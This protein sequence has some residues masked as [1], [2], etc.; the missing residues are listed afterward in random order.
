[1]YH[2]TNLNDSGPGSL[3]EGVV[4]ANGPR[5]IVFEVSGTI[6]LKSKL[7]VETPCLTIAG[8]TAPGDGVTL[9]DQYFQ[10]RN[11]SDVV[12]RYLRVRLGDKNKPVGAD[13][14]LN[15]E[16]VHDVML[17]HVSASWGID[18]I[19]DLAYAS[20]VTL[21]W[22]I[23]A[24]ALNQS[25]HHKGEHAMLSSWR[26][27]KGNVTLH[28]NLFASS[29]NRHPTLGTSRETD[30]NSVVDFR[31]NV[32]YNWEGPTNLGNCRIDVIGN[33]Y[34]PGPNTT[35]TRLPLSVKADRLDVHLAHG[36]LR[37]NLFEHNAV[38]TR[39][40]YLA[41]NYTSDDGSS[42]G[43]TTRAV[44][45]AGGPYVSAAEAPA[46]Q[47][48]RPR[49]RPCSPARGRRARVTRSTVAWCRECARESTGAST[50]KTRSA[51]GPSWSG[52]SAPPTATATVWPTIGNAPTASTRHR[53]TIATPTATA[54][55]IPTSRNTSTGCAPGHGLDPSR[56]EKTFLE[57]PVRVVI[58]RVFP[59]STSS[60]KS[61]PRI[62]LG[63]Q[64]MNR[65][66][67]S[68]GFTLIELL[69]VIAIIA[70]LIALL[71]PAVQAAREAAR[72]MSCVNNLKQIGIAMHN[73]HDVTGQLPS[74]HLTTGPTVGGSG[75]DDWS[76]FTMML[77]YMELGTLYNALNFTDLLEPAKYGNKYNSTV[78]FSKINTFLCPS[79]PVRGTNPDGH[80]NYAG[81]AG[82][83]PACTN[84]LL[85]LIGPD[86]RQCAQVHEQDREFRRHHRR[87]EQHRGVQRAG[88]GPH[89]G[90]R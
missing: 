14:T 39:D 34:R 53:P 2:V 11:T 86:R 42:Y 84:T 85:A 78:T 23:F 22:S 67:R 21:Q 52:P 36:Y 49:T 62:L 66:P 82:S 24:E 45:E 57:L 87:P 48:P 64:A 12:V 69:V 43:S 72:R 61:P 74:G 1:M 75:W 15:V 83:C 37:D 29:R 44:F 89:A 46:T 90:R 8:Q 9:K 7:A 13:D 18:G 33:Y 81:N 4:S 88:D 65:K 54:T 47:A 6:E 38:W 35:S 58:L 70:V 31:N 80:T 77:P 10:L 32:V 71:L 50:R 16:H 5:T 41:V 20:N 55:A 60:F 27:L 3:R 19:M 51:A 76:A 79:D 25:L 59:V 28:H 26:K 73:Y 68:A 30:P 56:G 40:N 17:D 63:T